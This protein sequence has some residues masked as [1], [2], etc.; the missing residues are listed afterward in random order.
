MDDHEDFF[1]EEYDKNEP[2][3]KDR[4]IVFDNQ[5]QKKY[6]RNDSG[7]TRGQR[8]LFWFIIACIVIVCSIAYFRYYNPYVTEA[9]ISGYITTVEKRGLIFKTFEGEMISES[10]VTDKT[11]FYTKDFI[12][13]VPDDSLARQIQ[14]YEGTGKKVTLIYQK[15]YGSLPWRGATRNIAIALLP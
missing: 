2:V 6:N 14:N 1:L 8:L 5:S 11:R 9:K 13:S 3:D 10:A 7:K 12:F 15:Y 4:T